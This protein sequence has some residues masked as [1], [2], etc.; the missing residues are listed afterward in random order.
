MSLILSV[1]NMFLKLP[2]AYVSFELMNET[3]GNPM[4][5]LTPG[6]TGGGDGTCTKKHKHTTRIDTKAPH[7]H[8]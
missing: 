6:E 8:T 1:I 3:G 5:L 7:A 4:M 2:W